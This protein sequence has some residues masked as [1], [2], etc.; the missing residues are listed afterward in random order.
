MNIYLILL[1]IWAV[2]ALCVAAI[3]FVVKSRND[4]PTKKLQ[5]WQLVAYCLLIAALWPLMLPT[6]LWRPAS[7]VRVVREQLK[8]SKRVAVSDDDDDDEPDP[9]QMAEE[10]PEWTDGTTEYEDD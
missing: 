9:L 1:S 6:I 3:M 5:P 7:F 4:A 2:V 10:H 8:E